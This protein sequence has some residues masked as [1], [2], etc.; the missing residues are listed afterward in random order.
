M[1]KAYGGVVID[2]QGH[3]LLRKPTGH[4]D[5]YVWTFAKGRPN[6][7]ESPE[8][9]ALREVEEEIGIVA[10]IV[11][12]ITG[13]FI[14]GTTDNE[15]FLMAAMEDTK[16]LHETSSL[17]WANQGEAEKLISETTNRAGRFRDLQ[18]L[19]AAFKAFWRTADEDNGPIRGA[20]H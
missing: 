19:E 6:K 12:K 17:R 7:G 4:Y 1:E 14:G 9:T 15:Y 16:R 18:V 11:T 10:R 5:G 3:V 2:E 8:Q 13:S 20:P